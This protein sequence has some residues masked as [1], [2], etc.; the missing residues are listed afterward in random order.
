[1]KAILQFKWEAYAYA[2][3]M[4]VFAVY[5][6]QLLFY[7]L[8]AFFPETVGGRIVGGMGMVMS[9][10]FVLNEGAELYAGTHAF[11]TRFW[12]LLDWAINMCGIYA[13]GMQT[14]EYVYPVLVL[15]GDKSTACGIDAAALPPHPSGVLAGSVF[16]VLGW[17]KVSRRAKRSGWA[18]LYAH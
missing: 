4:N 9:M 5:I 12:Y 6:L 1:M 10:R 2:H 17:G 3:F 18:I 16:Q 15:A 11:S 13:V 14:V 7:T 8:H